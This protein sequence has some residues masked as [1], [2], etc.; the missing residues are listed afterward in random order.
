MRNLLINESD[1]ANNHGAYIIQFC[2][3]GFWTKVRVDDFFPCYPGGGP[4]YSRAHGPELW[5]LLVEKAF[6]KYCGSY[7]AIKSGWAFEAMIDLTGT[8]ALNE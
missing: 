4:I 1:A 7:E 6:A 3:L 8:I 5:V 2:K